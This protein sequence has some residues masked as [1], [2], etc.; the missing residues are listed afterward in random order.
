M[1]FFVTL[2]GLPFLDAYEQVKLVDCEIYMR[3]ESVRGVQRDA[4]CEAQVSVERL[5]IQK[6]TVLGAIVGDGW[7]RDAKKWISC[8]GRVCGDF[9]RRGCDNV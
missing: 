7:E 5:N 8:A 9:D 6:R 1:N 4:R 2:A 3:I